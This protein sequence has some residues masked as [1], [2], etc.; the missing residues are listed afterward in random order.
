MRV[1]CSYKR[2]AQIK[3]AANLTGGDGWQGSL[4]CSA[5]VRT[6]LLQSWVRTWVL[7]AS[8]VCALPKNFALNEIFKAQAGPV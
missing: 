3:I 8:D 6:A 1:A 5:E 7:P 2:L 4:H